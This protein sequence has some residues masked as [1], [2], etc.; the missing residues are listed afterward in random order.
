[1]LARWLSVRWGFVNIEGRQICRPCRW[2]ADGGDEIDE[3][4][5]VN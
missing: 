1:M 3:F 2:L 4:F 5:G